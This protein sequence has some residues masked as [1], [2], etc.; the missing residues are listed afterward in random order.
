MLLM[1]LL[2][3]MGYN[4]SGALVQQKHDLNIY[5]TMSLSHIEHIKDKKNT[6]KVES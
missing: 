4:M 1:R 5:E 3:K 6:Q 2:S